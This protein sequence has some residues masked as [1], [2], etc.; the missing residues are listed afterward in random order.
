VES[1]TELTVTDPTHP[2]F[3]RRFPVRSMGVPEHGAIYVSVVYRD[4]M[5]LR[6]PLAA[7]NLT[8]PQPGSPTKLTLDA[9]LELVT[10]AEQCEAVCPS[11]PAMSGDSCR[12]SSNSRSATNSR[13][14]STRC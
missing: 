9:V 7:T 14:S 12:L 10:L 11:D 6:I 4:T 5:T 1:V 8:A 2:L 3:G 13:S